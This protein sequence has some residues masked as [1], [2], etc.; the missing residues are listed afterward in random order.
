MTLDEYMDPK[1]SPRPRG[2]GRRRGS[3]SRSTSSSTV[4]CASTSG[5]AVRWTRH[6]SARAELEAKMRTTS[7]WPRKSA[8]E[9]GGNGRRRPHRFLEVRAGDPRGR[10]A[11]GCLGSESFPGRVGRPESGRGQRDYLARRRGEL[12]AGQKRRI[13]GY[14]H[15]RPAT[16]LERRMLEHANPVHFVL[17]AGRHGGVRLRTVGTRLV[18]DRRRVGPALLGHVYCWVLARVPPRDMTAPADERTIEQR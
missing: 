7:G 2:R 8:S 16:W 15:G 3:S 14:R 1:R 13:E 5:G 6:A 10:S 4:K 11:A 18:L 9:R 17:G 12:W